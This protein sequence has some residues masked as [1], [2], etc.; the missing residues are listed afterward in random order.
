MVYTE[1][2][3]CFLSQLTTTETLNSINLKNLNII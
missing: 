3:K 2:I 1:S